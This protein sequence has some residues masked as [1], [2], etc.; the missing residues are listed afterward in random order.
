MVC[1]KGK[2]IEK[3]NLVKLKIEVV[4]QIK[5]LFPSMKTKYVQD[6]LMNR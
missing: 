3:K 5:I 6:C 1:C 2:I 4:V